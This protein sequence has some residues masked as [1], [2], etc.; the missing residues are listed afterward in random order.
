MAELVGLV[1]ASAEL[2]VCDEPA[3]AW[4]R[5]IGL[6]CLARSARERLEEA[7]EASAR[8]VLT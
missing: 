3:L 4:A 1:H 6:A 7:I 5:E 8:D 2:A